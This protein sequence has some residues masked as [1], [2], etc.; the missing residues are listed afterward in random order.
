[1]ST[2]TVIKVLKSRSCLKIILFLS[3]ILYQS[4]PETAVLL[5]TAT[6]QNGTVTTKFGKLFTARI[7]QSMN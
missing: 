3:L 4:E 5:F 1:M 7:Y 6:I 2:R